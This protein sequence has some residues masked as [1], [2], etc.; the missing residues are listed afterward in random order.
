MKMEKEIKIIFGLRI[1]L[2]CSL[3]IFLII[4]ITSIKT[5]CQDC[6]FEVEEETISAS[7]FF[8]KYYDRCLVSRDPLITTPNISS[9]FED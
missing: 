6:S 7:S 3:I 2:L 1:I 5:D 4:F 8:Q 9:F